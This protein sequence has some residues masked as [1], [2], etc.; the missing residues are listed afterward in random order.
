MNA[1]YLAAR[2]IVVTMLS[3]FPPGSLTKEALSAQVDAA[4]ALLN[5]AEGID[6]AP[7]ERERLVTEIETKFNVWIGTPRILEDDTGHV[8]WLEGRRESIQWR[9][10]S[11]YI[12]YLRHEWATPKTLQSIEQLTDDILERLEDPERQGEWDRRG[13]VVGHVQSGKTA[14]YTGLI[15]KAVDAGYKLVVVLAGMHN[16]LRSQTQVR[17]EAGFLG[18]SS[19]AGEVQR[20]IGV[21]LIDPGPIAGTITDRT[22]KGDFSKRVAQ[23]F[24]IAP[25]QQPLLFV[26][27]K[28]VYTLRNL[29]KWV[30]G[31]AN[32][33]ETETGRYF[34]GGVPILVIDDEADQASVN[35]SKLGLRPTR[36]N[37]LIRQLLYTFERSA[38]VGYTATPFANIFI[39]DG[40]RSDD[41]GQD[42]FPRSFI[43]NLPAPSNYMGPARVFGLNGDPDAGIEGTP[44]MPL[45]RSADDGRE[46]MPDKHKKDWIPRHPTELSVPQSLHEAML[47]F[48]LAGAA[49]QARGMGS[50]HHSMLVHVTRFTDVQEKVALQVGEHLDFLKR[51]IIYGDGGKKRQLMDELRELWLQD[52]V[53]TTERINPLLGEG[54]APLIPLSWEQVRDEIRT[55]I[56]AIEVRV[57]NG[58][59]ADALEYEA[60]QDE[61]LRIIAI[62]GNKLSRG[63]TLEGLTTSY[64]MRSSKMY[65]TLMQMGRWF[66]FRQGYIDVCRLY[67]PGDLREWFEHIA[68]ASEEL[69]REF[70]Y[71]TITGGTPKDY[72]LRVKS[73]PALLITS[74][75]KMRAGVPLRLSF[76]GD[77][78][79]TVV[80]PRSMPA[81]KFNYE[82]AE[83]FI[84]S[85]GS[86]DESPGDSDANSKKLVWSKRS[87]REVIKFLQTYRTHPLAWR[88]NT[89]LLS[90]FIEKQTRKGHLQEWTVCLVSNSD[91][92]APHRV[93]AGYGVGL[94]RRGTAS[95]GP[96]TDR[97]VVRRLV[98]PVDE[99]IDLTPDEYQEALNRTKNAF[100]G[101][102]DEVKRASGRYIREVRGPSRGLLLIY[103]LDPC[104]VGRDEGLD[105][106]DTPVIGFATSFPR[107]DDAETVEYKVNHVYWEQYYG[108]NDWDDE[109]D[110]S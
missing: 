110:E 104:K 73:H 62:G 18:Y 82:A 101:D 11:R 36:I 93:I 106:K 51:S 109:E 35:S 78:S 39:H 10:W 46:W 87:A 7:E 97:L 29:L 28:N 54:D 95:S 9:F 76:A 74:Q 20:P 69:R 75:V 79:E 85:L 27:K 12:D 55:T 17:L 53:P 21:G 26:V 13:L 45:V 103:P 23:Q 83:S 22:D 98:S 60:H 4:A 2:D 32:D 86:P 38:Y 66:G 80:F 58:K 41:F 92:D 71:M 59:S 5:S 25:G 44:A 65:D 50:Q 42:L 48:I 24:N 61:G 89:A 67:M 15:C 43:I 84:C 107:I 105:D 49:R 8:R 30:R 100:E 99:A 6:L 72:G 68:E 63:L 37:G 94:T 14:N 57:V 3:H 1:A 88:V 34:V 90:E 33:H 77:T 70:D 47:S 19:L 96:Y 56:G 102:P 52:F 91:R 81:L 64:F 108:A 16:N 31:F 40:A